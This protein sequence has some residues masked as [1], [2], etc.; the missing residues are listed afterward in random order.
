ML[1]YTT[2]WKWFKSYHIFLY[3]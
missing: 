1:D 2:I 3:L